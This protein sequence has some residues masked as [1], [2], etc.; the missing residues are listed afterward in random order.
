MW[1]YVDGTIT[2]PNVTRA[3]ATERATVQAALEVWTKQD[4]KARS[5]LILSISPPELKHVR[6]CNTSK[7]IWDRLESIYASKGPARKATL[8][9]RL[10]QQKM[11][12]KAW[13]TR[14]DRKSNV[15]SPITAKSSAT[16]EW[17]RY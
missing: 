11:H 10:S 8:L 9:K 3:S 13:K 4:K 5:D 15:W 16:S 7:E 2:A 1:G 17:T 6:D 14:Q 12:R